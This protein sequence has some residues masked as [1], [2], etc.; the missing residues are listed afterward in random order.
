MVQK[1]SHKIHCVANGNCLFR[2]LSHKTFSDQMYHGQM[3]AA[4][5]T[6]II[7]NF[8]HFILEIIHF[9]GMLVLCVRMVS[10]NASS[11]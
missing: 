3:R 10:G 1:Y 9:V 5:V 4:L 8:E 11:R 2:A 6:Q 7:N